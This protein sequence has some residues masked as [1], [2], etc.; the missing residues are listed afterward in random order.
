MKQKKNKGSNDKNKQEEPK[1]IIARPGT[2]KR[3]HQVRSFL[4]HMPK[5]EH[6][7]IF[8]DTEFEHK[9]IKLPSLSGSREDS[10]D[11]FKLQ[12]NPTTPSSII[13]PDT[14]TPQWN[15][16]SPRMLEPTDG[17]SND[18]Y[19]YQLQKKSKMKNWSNVNRKPK[20]TFLMTPSRLKSSHLPHKGR[21]K[22]N[23]TNLFQDRVNLQS[24]D[25]KEDEDYY[26]S[27]SE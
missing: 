18:Q 15:H 8:N 9:R 22:S 4:E 11:F 23:I 6:E 27:N 14:K 10:D 19:V 24:D 16:I 7:D 13:F 26:F 21:Q 12:T 1:K 3:K 2:L 5:D 25:E 17:A 20:Q